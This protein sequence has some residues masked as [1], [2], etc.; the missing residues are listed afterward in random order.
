MDPNAEARDS[1]S[2]ARLRLIQRLRILFASCAGL[3]IAATAL[4]R[5]FPDLRGVEALN[6]AI[7]AMAAVALIALV[8]AWI[9]YARVQRR[10]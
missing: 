5:A 2:T 6:W 9:S 8:A 7:L 3:S 4:L 1:G 10:A